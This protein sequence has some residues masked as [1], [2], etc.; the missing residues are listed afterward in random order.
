MIHGVGDGRCKSRNPGF[1]AVTSAIGRHPFGL[2]AG[3]PGVLVR[4][5]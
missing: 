1:V 4:H 3:P 5:D 2:E